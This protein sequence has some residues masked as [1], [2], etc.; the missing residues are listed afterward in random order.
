MWVE[1]KCVFLRG[2]EVALDDQAKATA[3]DTIPMLALHARSHTR[4]T[5]CAE[6]ST[7]VSEKDCRPCKLAKLLTLVWNTL[8]KPHIE[9]NLVPLHNLKATRER[10]KVRNSNHVWLCSMKGV[11]GMN[12]GVPCPRCGEREGR[13]SATNNSGRQWLEPLDTRTRPVKLS[14]IFSGFGKLTVC[15]VCGDFSMRLLM[16]SRSCV[17]EPA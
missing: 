14:F 6:A 7:T 16:V 2:V 4:N 8:H 3:H 10:Y 1:F 9:A 12:S 17:L 13:W 11:I 5:C 15:Q